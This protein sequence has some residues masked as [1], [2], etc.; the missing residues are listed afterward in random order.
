[1]NACSGFPG[2]KKGCPEKNSLFKRKRINYLILTLRVT[3]PSLVVIF[4]K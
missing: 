2:Q 3:T 4:S 1:M